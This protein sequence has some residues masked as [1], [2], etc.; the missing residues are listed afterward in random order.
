MNLRRMNRSRDNL[1]RLAIRT[2]A[3]SALEDTT[4]F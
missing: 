2:I 1:H 4:P 3:A